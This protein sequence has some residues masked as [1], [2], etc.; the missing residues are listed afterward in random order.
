MWVW[1]G[2]TL[3]D[4]QTVAERKFLSLLTIPHSPEAG[5]RKGG[6]CSH[7]PPQWSKTRRRLPLAG[8][9]YA[10]REATMPFMDLS[11]LC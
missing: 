8:T 10:H 6:A 11:S 7:F 2:L 9:A 4:S 3:S 5:R 1:G